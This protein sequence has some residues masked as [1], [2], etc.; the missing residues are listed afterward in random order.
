MYCISITDSRFDDCL[1][2]AKKCEKLLKRDPE[3]V[4]EVRLD[5]CNLSEKEVRLLF[6]ESKVPMIAICRKSTKHLAEAAVQ[7]G[8]KYID[9]DI[10]SSDSFF[11]SLAPTLRKRNLKKILSYS[12]FFS[13]PQLEELKDICRRGVKRGA[14][15]IRI[16]T[17]PKSSADVERVLQL[18]ECY[19]NGEFGK[20]I[21]L[22]AFAMGYLGRY[23]R[24]EALNLGAPF[25]Y[26]TLTAEDRW[27][28]G[29]LS[30]Q[31][32]EKFAPGNKI[33]GEFTIPASKSIAQRAIIA[34]SL[35]KGESEFTNLSRCADIDYALGVSKQVG[36]VV[37]ILGDTIT[38]NGKGFRNIIKQAS[39]APSSLVSAIVL[40]QTLD[41]FVGESGLLSRLCIPL[42]AQL[43]EGVTITGAG[44]LLHREMVGCKESI[45]EFQAKCILSAENTL[46][47]VV[48]GP[49]IGGKVSI[50]GKK[51]SQLISGLLMALP[52]SKKNSTLTITNATSLPYIKLTLDVIKNFGIEMECHEADGNIVFEIPGKQTYQP[53]TLSI[54]GDWS[55]AANFI[56]AG[57]LFGNIFIKGLK[58]DTLQAD[59][60]ILDIIRKSGGYIQEKNG[61][62][63][64]KQS[65]LKA[66]E[67]DTANTPDLFPILAIMAAFCEGESAI[68]GVEK[69]RTKESDRKEVIFDILQKMGVDVEIYD[70]TMF[71]TGMSYSRRLLEG[72]NIKKGTYNSHNDHRVAMAILLASLGTPE[73]VESNNVECINKSF[74][75]FLT[76]FNSLKTNNVIN[77]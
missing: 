63:I 61:G 66:F 12:N 72:K 67:Y 21:E 17:T 25:M 38:I 19:R 8:A 69:L 54:E 37:D 28:I 44:S 24:I 3:L 45:E 5:L 39:Q 13:T 55:S 56:V 76:L 42:A 14:D 46:P 7:S 29:Q 43:G 2:S 75:K 71:I 58:L 77:K 11:T 64:I 31:Q 33:A 57:A 9:I 62:L 70:G 52:L 60:A 53:A 73:K 10:L 4:A 32:M 49:L 6:L 15:I 41:L 18:Y 40:P 22:I 59:R 74:P 34:A 68:K 51:G 23:T 35:A 47:A 65:H 20:N 30:I 26:C 1:K 36:A 27:N 50:S 48:S 16:A